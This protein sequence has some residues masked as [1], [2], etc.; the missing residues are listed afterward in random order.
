MVLLCVNY[1]FSSFFYTDIVFLPSHILLNIKSTT[2]NYWA[3]LSFQEQSTLF[4]AQSDM[5]TIFH[6]L[7]VNLLHNLT[8]QHALLGNITRV[9]YY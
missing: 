3:I 9:I 7:V 6:M 8:Y 1:S 4:S 2:I 5:I